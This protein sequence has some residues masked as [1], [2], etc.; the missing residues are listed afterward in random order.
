MHHH[1]TGLAFAVLL[2]ASAPCAL[3]DTTIIHAD[4]LL[5][6]PGMAAQPRQ[7]IVIED[8]RIVEVSNGQCR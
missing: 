6:V 1:L 4:E 3:A 7:T 5:A 8:D 2:I